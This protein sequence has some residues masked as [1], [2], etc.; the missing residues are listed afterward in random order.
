MESKYRYKV[1]HLTSV[2]APTDTRIVHREC[3][4]LAQAGY[5][6]VLIAPGKV[7]KLPPGVRH[8]PIRV[9]RNRFE[10]MTRTIWE[11][12]LSARDERANVYHF[13]DPELMFV[14]LALRLS[15][16]S[17]VFDV[18]EDIPRDI[19]DKPWIPSA[20]RAPISL[21]AAVVL[22]AFQRGF[23]AIV[24]STPGI[25]RGFSHRKT[26]VVANFP[27]LSAF[28]ASVRRPFVSRAR[29]VAYVGSITRD[30]GII[31]L[32]EALA[33]PSMVA[34]GRLVL[35][36]TFEDEE[37]LHEAQSMPGWSRVTYLGQVDF[38][39][40]DDVLM[41]VRAG[42]VTLLPSLNFV[43]SLPT[44]MFEYLAAGLPVVASNFLEAAEIL[45]EHEC[46]VSV[47][48]FDADAIARTISF[49]IENPE[50][51]Q[52]MGQRG[53]R[54]VNERYQWTSEGKKLTNLYSE[55]A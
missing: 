47:D 52:A 6:V 3:A 21:A 24:T 8:R 17:V 26:V 27:K 1:A 44:K 30:R 51:A 28:S 15:G 43:A 42:L 49:F 9:P 25:A 29:A 38:S 4:T 40:L 20:L 48:P 32:I 23:S 10:R 33:S 46:G 35:V 45:Q 19:V 13:H 5:D 39:K 31:K 14:G 50:I 54:V 2:H 36:G 22:R 16:A 12:F 41:D 11:V 7:A 37:L 53:R 18:H 34:D 55:I